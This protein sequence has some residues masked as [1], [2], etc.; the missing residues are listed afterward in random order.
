MDEKAILGAV[1]KAVEVRVKE[2]SKTLQDVGDRLDRATKTFVTV[3]LQDIESEAAAWILGQLGQQ[4][5]FKPSLNGEVRALYRELNAC[6]GFLRK[7]YRDLV[8][9]EAVPSPIEAETDNDEPGSA[10]VAEPTVAATTPASDTEVEPELALAA[11]TLMERT[12]RLVDGATK[13]QIQGKDIIMQ[14]IHMLAAETRWCVEALPS[15]HP[16]CGEWPVVL[17]MLRDLQRRTGVRG[18]IKGLSQHVTGENWRQIANEASGQVLLLRLPDGHVPAFPRLRA[19]LD[20]GKKVYLFGGIRK[21]EKIR[22]IYDRLDITV[23]W[24]EADGPER[25]RTLAQRIQ[26]GTVAGLIVLERLVNHSANDVLR[27][28]CRNAGVPCALGGSAGLGDIA[29]A[30]EDLEIALSKTD[31]VKEPG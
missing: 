8:P 2:Q 13:G 15:D 14:S 26:S 22:T 25:A 31:D 12:Q 11:D 27:A 9:K 4:T 29:V 28:A 10:R 6:L 20:Q 19:R 18:F 17:S 1:R 3:A 30:F 23:E 7:Y 16:K 24:V 5:S 21:P